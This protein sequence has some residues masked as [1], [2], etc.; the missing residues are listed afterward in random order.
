MI[1]PLVSTNWLHENIDDPDL[2]ILDAS[3]ETNKSNLTVAFPGI[4]IKGARFFDMKNSFSDKGN[5]VPNMI[6]SSEVFAEECKKLGINN[7]SKIVV[8]DNLGIYTSPRVW[9]MFKVMGH[10][11]IAVLDGGLSAWE[12]EGYDCEA[13]VQ[14]DFPKGD[15]IANYQ[16]GLVKNTTEVLQNINVGKYTVIDARSSG[17]FNGTAPEPRANLKSGHIPNSK[18]LPYTQVL[19]DGK[20]LPKEELATIFE[21]LNPDKEPLVFTCGSGLTAC[22]IL[23]AN[24][25]VSDNPKS[26]YD[27]SWSEW[28]AGNEYPI[29]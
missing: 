11:A 23:L 27:G 8:Y 1:Q 4:Q 29:S 10:D 25:L 24:D 21:T 7:N 20:F 17:R 16:P 6:P 15:F 3:P 9:W 2:L 13:I 18:S 22:I 5:P 12:K 26:L 19:K 14:P 28:G